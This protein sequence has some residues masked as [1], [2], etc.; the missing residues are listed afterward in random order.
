RKCPSGALSYSMDGI[1]YNKIKDDQPLVTISKDGPY[2]ITGGIE[3]LGER[4]IA[5]GASKEHY[6]LCRCGASNNKPFCDGSHYGIDF[7]DERN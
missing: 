1:E 3:L 7:K 4:Q 2:I 5:E 6:V